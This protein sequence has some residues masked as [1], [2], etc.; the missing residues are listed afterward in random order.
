MT[1]KLYKQKCFSHIKRILTKNLVT[2]TRWDVDY[3]QKM[4]YITGVHW[5]TW[6]LGRGGSRK[7]QYLGGDCLKKGIWT[8]CRFKRE[9]RVVF[10]RRGWYE[11]SDESFR[12]LASHCFFQDWS[13]TKLFILRASRFWKDYHSQSCKIRI[14]EISFSF[15]FCSQLGRNMIQF[16]H[17]PDFRNQVQKNICAF[18]GTTVNT[19]IRLSEIYS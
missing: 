10:L 5:K 14:T 18:F 19:Y 3:V 12:P 1:K 17:I 13:Y 15:R 7:N 2:F 11:I 8:I 6:F 9:L 16:W 4:L